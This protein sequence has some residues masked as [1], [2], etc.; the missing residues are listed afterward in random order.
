[1]T[2]APSITHHEIEIVYHEHSDDWHFTLRG[3]E[4]TAKSLTAAKEAID[5]PTPKKG[6]PFERFEAWYSGGFRHMDF[7][8]VTVSS[9]VEPTASYRRWD[10]LRVKTD[11]GIQVVDGSTV[12]SKNAKNDAVIAD[13]L[14]INREIDK[15]DKDR[16]KMIAKLVPVKIEPEGDS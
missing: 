1:M 2:D 4:R 10:R 8:T 9:I 16:E 14:A 12:Y 5:K 15:L 11:E 3:R 7:K 6:K 13:I